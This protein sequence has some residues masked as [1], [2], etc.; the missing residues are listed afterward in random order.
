M[1]ILD[2]CTGEAVGSA[3]IARANQKT[4]RKG[5][6]CR[7]GE[8][9]RLRAL[10]WVLKAIERLLEFCNQNSKRPDCCT[11]PVREAIPSPALSFESLRL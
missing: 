8:A 11:V 5:V 2:K 4:T 6:F 1:K 7:A 10:R 9:K 3:P